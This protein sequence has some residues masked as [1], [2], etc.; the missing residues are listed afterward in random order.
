MDTQCT[1]VLWDWVYSIFTFT[2]LLIHEG[3]FTLL[4]QAYI[5]MRVKMFFSNCLSNIW[6]SEIC[7]DAEKANCQ[8]FTAKVIFWIRQLSNSPVLAFGF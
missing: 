1:R 4:S 5:S 3:V 2:H 7:G 8:G 6:H